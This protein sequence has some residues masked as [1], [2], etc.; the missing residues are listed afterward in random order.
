[1]LFDPSLKQMS[2]DIQAHIKAEIERQGIKVLHI[3]A[4]GYLFDSAF[5]IA[6]PTDAARDRLTRDQD[7]MARLKAYI[8]ETGYVAQART[9][10]GKALAKINSE[11]LFDIAIVFESQQTVD[12]DFEGNWFYAMK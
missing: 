5:W 10:H 1:M 7:L 6:V 4:I 12:R 9:Q 11:H 2:A 3:S 8:D